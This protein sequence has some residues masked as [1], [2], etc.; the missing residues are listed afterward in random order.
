[1]HNRFSPEVH[2]LRSVL[3]RLQQTLISVVPDTDK[4]WIDTLKEITG[5]DLKSLTTSDIKNILMGIITGNEGIPWDFYD[6]VSQL[7]KYI[8]SIVRDTV[9]KDVKIQTG[10]DYE[11]LRVTAEGH[12]QIV[13]EV[14]PNDSVADYREVALY[15]YIPPEQARA[16]IVP[17]AI[18]DH[19]ASCV[20]L[21]RNN[22]VLPAASVLSIA[23]ESTLWEA[24]QNKGI[25]RSREHIVY[26]PVKWYLRRTSDKFLVTIEGADKNL[27]E[28]DTMVQYPNGVTSELRKIQINNAEQTAML[29]MTIDKDLVSFF[30]SD[31]TESTELKT[32]RGP[33]A[34]MQRGRSADIEC[35][36]T[37][38]RIYDEALVLLRNNL[39]HLPS[40]GNLEKPIPIPGKGQIQ[41]IEELRSKGLFIKQL[42][43]LVIEVI[44]IVYFV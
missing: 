2:E 16:P 41:T 30:A 3:D 17:I 27:K 31:Q 25:T 15:W 42:L 20:L 9:I 32:D 11:Y 6:I 21:L 8:P 18:I 5:S 36:R 44:K 14:D 23:L 34:A 13:W 38:P 19:I 4:I 28:M 33:S 26:A 35:L 24:L 12:W 1:M 7:I 10:Y 39:I 29:Q 37:I 22:L 43:Y 40:Q